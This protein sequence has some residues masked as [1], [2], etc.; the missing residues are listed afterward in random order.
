ML[1]SAKFVT[2][3]TCLVNAGRTDHMTIV[4]VR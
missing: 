2:P 1:L 3:S 4:V